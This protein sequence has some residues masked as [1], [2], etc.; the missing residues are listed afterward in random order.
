[1]YYTVAQSPVFHS[2]ILLFGEYSLILNS[3]G[4]ALPYPLFEGRLVLKHIAESSRRI[5]QSNRE[6]KAFCDYM[7]L[8]KRQ[9]A[10]SFDFDINSMEF[11][12]AQGLYFQ[13]NIPQGFGVGSSGALTAALYERYVYDKI[14][15]NGQPTNE[16]IVRLKKIFSEMESHFHGSSSGVDPLICYLN[17]PLLIRSKTQIEPVDLPPPATTDGGIFLLNTG[18]PRKT[19]PLVNLFL[20]KMQHAEF[21]DLCRY[22]LIPHNENC[23][24]YFLTGQIEELFKELAQLSA[25]QLRYFTPMIPPLFRPIW[26]FG[27]ES[28]LYYLK[29][30][31]A[32]GGGFILGFTQNFCLARGH[33]EDYQS[34]IAYRL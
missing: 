8:R 23:I 14:L 20:E 19:E 31:G 7:K 4:L 17:M 15:H 9:Q 24:R 28:G 32:G 34:R 12:V 11:D 16:E 18:R 5:D 3:M 26:Q 21:A 2:K 1:M 6:L 27:I 13:S 10:L 30:C 33:L 22:Q 25:F 29:L